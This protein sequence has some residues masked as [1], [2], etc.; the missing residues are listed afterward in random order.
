[1]LA[2]TPS[3]S[4]P[5]EILGW[6]MGWVAFCLLEMQRNMAENGFKRNRCFQDHVWCCLG[7]S[8]PLPRASHYHQSSAGSGCEAQFWYSE[9]MVIFKAQ[10]G[11]SWNLVFYKMNDVKLRNWFS[12][13]FTALGIVFSCMFC[14]L[15]SFIG[16]QCSLHRY[17]G[18][19]QQ[20]RL[21]G[22]SAEIINGDRSTVSLK[23]AWVFLRLGL[24][25]S[26]SLWGPRLRALRLL[27]SPRG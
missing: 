11:S 8:P 12:V 21:L 2:P 6:G 14:I 1:M 9:Q 18:K 7:C 19:S 22:Y 3:P 5:C 16:V 10:M 15:K 27:K 4:S 23:S 20:F 26:P 17:K 24:V 13:M 25:W